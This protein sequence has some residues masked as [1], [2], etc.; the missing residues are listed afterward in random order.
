MAPTIDTPEQKERKMNGAGVAS[1]VARLENEVKSIR[2]LVESLKQR[3][4]ALEYGKV[5]KP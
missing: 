2:Q 1:K 5:A 3:V 4:V